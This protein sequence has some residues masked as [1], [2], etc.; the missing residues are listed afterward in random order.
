MAGLIQGVKDDFRHQK[1]YL[2]LFVVLLTKKK[3][4]F[5]QFFLLMVFS[6]IVLPLISFWFYANHSKAILDYITSFR[7]SVSFINVLLDVISLISLMLWITAPALYVFI[8]FPLSVFFVKVLLYRIL[9]REITDL[10]N[11]KSFFAIFF[12]EL[13]GI[14]KLTN[15]S[16]EIFS[17]YTSSKIMLSRLRRQFWNNP[18]NFNLTKY[19]AVSELISTMMY[20]SV[21]YAVYHGYTR[22]TMLKSY[23]IA[24]RYPFPIVFMILFL[25]LIL[26]LAIPCYILFVSFIMFLANF[27]SSFVSYNDLSTLTFVLI[28]VMIFVI[29]VILGLYYALISFLVYLKFNNN[30]AKHAET[31]A[32]NGGVLDKAFKY[33]DEIISKRYGTKPIKMDVK[34]IPIKEEFKKILEA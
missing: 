33:M 31:E 16:M 3:V 12:E 22:D 18:E 24:K 32:Y 4:I 6:I 9:I 34:Y 5:L 30:L 8:V 2:K 13:I 11:N 25:F 21:D 1:K 14:R 23:I 27:T 20:C 19:M 29:V 7:T 17:L 15:L 28:W 10:D 26:L